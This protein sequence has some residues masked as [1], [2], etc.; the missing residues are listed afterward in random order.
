[1][2]EKLYDPTIIEINRLQGRI[3]GKLIAIGRK[4]GIVNL[5]WESG[6]GLRGILPHHRV[7]QSITLTD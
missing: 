1:M 7:P 6:V 2:K 5:T 3:T 4:N